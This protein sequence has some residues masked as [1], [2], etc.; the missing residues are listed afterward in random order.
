M[1]LLITFKQ[2]NWAPIRFTA[3]V[4]TDE[5]PQY[6]EVQSKFSKSP[7][8]GAPFT[9]EPPQNTQ[10]LKP[11]QNS[12]RLKAKI[13]QNPTNLHL[14]SISWM[15][16]LNSSVWSGGDGNELV[17]RWTFSD[18]HTSV[19]LKG[20]NLFFLQHLTTCAIIR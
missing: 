15:I 14:V 7:D 19:T 11:P 13:K 17:H 1:L 2:W 3:A 16:S 8:S 20:S 6:T 18:V 10:Y 5:H 4:F 12:A 9:Q